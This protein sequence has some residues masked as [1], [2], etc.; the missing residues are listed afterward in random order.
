MNRYAFYVDGFNLYHVIDRYHPDCKWLNVFQ[1]IRSLI[2]RS[3]KVE[4]IYYFSAIVDWKPKRSNR[5][6]AYLNALKTSNVKVVLGK[7]KKKDRKCKDCGVK[8][9]AHEEKQTDVNIALQVFE[10]AMQN[11][12]DCL[13][14]RD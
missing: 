10:D 4:N 7:F 9:I 1:M 5:Q 3:A 6:N 14:L 12:F 8:Y 2:P 11:N 13:L